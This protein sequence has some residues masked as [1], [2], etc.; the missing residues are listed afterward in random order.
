MKVSKIIEISELSDV[1][2]PFLFTKKL[3]LKDPLAIIVLL[4]LATTIIVIKIKQII[5]Q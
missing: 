1:F 2:S 3:S 4:F 5:Q